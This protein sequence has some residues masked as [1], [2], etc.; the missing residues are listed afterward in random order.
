MLRERQAQQKEKKCNPNIEIVM[1]GSL[2]MKVYGGSGKT[3]STMKNLGSYNHSLS[4]RLG[5]TNG[6]IK[7]LGLYN[8]TST[9]KSNSSREVYPLY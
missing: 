3:H 1:T 2:Q 8:G 4:K 7:K 6:T 5:H 9:G